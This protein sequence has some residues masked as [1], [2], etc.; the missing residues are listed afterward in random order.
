MRF[1]LVLFVVLICCFCNKAYT[2]VDFNLAVDS[3]HVDFKCI[4][5]NNLSVEHTNDLIFLSSDYDG[6]K[7]MFGKGVAL[8]LKTVEFF[9]P[10]KI[11]KLFIEAYD[12]KYEKMPDDRKIDY[13]WLMYDSNNNELVGKLS[14]TTYV[15]D[16]PDGYVDEHLLEL[17]LII[18][19]NY[20]NKK[21]ISTI[22]PSLLKY[23]SGFEEFEDKRFCF[24]TSVDNVP[25][26]RIA[27]K[28]GAQLIFTRQKSIDFIVFKKKLEKD[29]FVV[30]VAK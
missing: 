18:A 15:D 13:H 30:D 29:L 8:A 25:V 2:K 19:P 22:T 6:V 11:L 24:D 28:I 1:T 5:L 7:S 21:I 3:I 9:S 20:R 4:S 17:G 26:H 14:I 12:Q 10:G 23:L 27:H 16:L